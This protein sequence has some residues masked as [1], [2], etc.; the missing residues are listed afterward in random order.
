MN[1]G[2]TET[3]FTDRRFE[4]PGGQRDVIGERT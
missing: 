3:A 4:Q 2:R 1:I